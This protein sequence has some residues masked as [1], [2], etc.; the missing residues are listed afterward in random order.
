[1]RMLEIADSTNIEAVGYDPDAMRLHV[2]FRGGAE[3]VYRNVE[4][5]MFGQLI[6]ADSVGKYF[7]STIKPNP[8]K[9]PF[10]RVESEPAP[11][12]R[13][14]QAALALIASCKK[15]PSDVNTALEL[16]EIAQGALGR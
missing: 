8:D 15:D 5:W 12:V 4:D 3:Y 16:V 10:E 11:D 6:A 13:K 14:M 2:K 1:M 7:S 9:F